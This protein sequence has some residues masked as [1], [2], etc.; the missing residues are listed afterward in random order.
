MD[1]RGFTL[2]EMV[3]ATAIMG[4]AIVGLL[5]GISGAARNA[6]RLRE[7]DRA[8]QLARLRMNDLLLD[9]ALPRDAE[10]EG[11][12]EGSLTGG[13]EAG[14]RARRS[15]FE[16]PPAPVP[17]GFALDRIQLEV[18]W[19][20]GAQRRTFTLDGFRRRTLKP[21]DIPPPEATQ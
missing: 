12:F 3:V 18:W 15:I 5:S 1:R 21:E 2:L 14:W 7:H 6:A 19:M 8:V 11:T 13:I 9:D 20:S 16:M 4:I 10:V 17:G